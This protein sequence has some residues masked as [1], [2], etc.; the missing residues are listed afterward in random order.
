M[1][2]SWPVG[3]GM[4]SGEETG[5]GHPVLYA[6]TERVGGGQQATGLGGSP[7][8]PPPYLG[9]GNTGGVKT[10]QTLGSRGP[11]GSRIWGEQRSR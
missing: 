11:P 1:A 3:A 7:H 2:V 5:R 10:R 8:G 9:A 6:R 4:R